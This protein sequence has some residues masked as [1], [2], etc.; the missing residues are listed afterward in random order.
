MSVSED[1]ID[2]SSPSSAAPKNPKA[3]VS[4]SHDSKEHKAWVAALAVRLVNDGIDVMFDGFDMRP[5]DDVVKY[6]ERSVVNAQHVLMICSETYVRKADDGKGGVGYEVMIV[7]GE[8][9]RNLGTGKFIPVIRQNTSD[10]VSP[11]CVSTRNW[12]NLSEGPAYEEEYDKLLRHLHEA[13][14]LRKPPIGPNPYATDDL[15]GEASLVRRERRRT[16]F[17]LALLTPKA[18]YDFALQTMQV[19][20]RVTWRPSPHCRRMATHRFLIERFTSSQHAG[21][22][23]DA[24]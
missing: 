6:M 3:F 17:A 20:D 16:D 8:L 2:P 18:T 1:Y 23:G 11:V 24:R 12:I 19:D 7:T 9:V 5:G 21:P 15:A 13:P 10:P 4:Y 22:V 14:K